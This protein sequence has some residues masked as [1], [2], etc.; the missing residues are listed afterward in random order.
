MPLAPPLQPELPV[1]MKLV[2]FGLAISSSWGNGHDTLWRGLCAAL[3]RRGHSVV[4]FER[5]VPYY[6]SH[7]DLWSVPGG[8]LHLYS[9]WEDVAAAAAQELEDADAGM[10]TSFCPDATAAERRRVTNYAE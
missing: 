8:H 4:F 6:A 7:R 2:V 3:A 10:V 5:D 1:K 9:R